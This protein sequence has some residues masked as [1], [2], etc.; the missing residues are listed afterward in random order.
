MILPSSVCVILYQVDE[1]LDY[2]RA[3]A[4]FW[5]MDE[6]GKLPMRLRAQMRVYFRM[7]ARVRVPIA[8]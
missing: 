1:G 3:R 2:D 6:H 8:Y 5:V 7:I 4:N